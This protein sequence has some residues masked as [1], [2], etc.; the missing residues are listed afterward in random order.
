MNER[1]YDFL[2]RMREIHRP[3]RRNAQIQCQP[4]EIEI[5]ASWTLALEGDFGTGGHKALADLQDYLWTSMRL[6]LR[7]AEAGT[8]AAPALRLCQGAVDGPKGS[9][10]L[11][12]AERGIVLTAPGL[13]G[14]WSG[15]V[16]LEDTMNL[17][18]APLLPLGRQE[19]RPLIRVRRTH[20]GCGI[21]DFPDWQLAAIAHAGFNTIDVFL[22][23]FDQTTRGYCDIR[24]LI[25]RAAEYGLDTFIY[26]YMPSYK[27]PDDPDAEAFFDSIYGELFRRY[28]K[29]AGIGLC[30]ESLEFPSKDPAT[31]GKRWRE[32]MQDGI[33]D[34]R[35]SP[36]WWPCQDYPAY[37]RCIARAIR[38]VKPDA[39]IIFNTYNWGYSPQAQRRKF[40]ESLPKDIIVQTTF[41]IFKINRID[42]LSCPIMDYTILATE[43]GDYFT[44]ECAMAHEL[45]LE[46]C[47]TTNT[48]GATWDFGTAPYVPA[49]YRWIKRFRH[50][51]E[52]LEKWG[53]ARHYET[54]HY[55]W[56]P[57]VVIDLRKANDWSPREEDLE[58]LLRRVAA[59]DYGEA[60]AD[61]VMA[62]WRL[63]SEAMDHYVASN[64]DQYGPWRVG[65]A[66]PLMFQPN[67][68][69]TR[70]SKEID[71]PAAPHAHF[72]G[73]I[74]K[75][76]Y[77]PYE[78]ARQ[79]PGPLRFPK[80]LKRLERMLA[81]WRLG[82]VEVEA[83]LAGMP[84]SKRPDGERLLALGRFIEHSIVT[85]I[86]VKRWWLLN[87]R[88]QASDNPEAMLAIVD[89]LVALAE[90]EMR[91]ARET[92][93][94]VE[95]DSRL[96][97]E[98]SMEYVCDK[99]HLEWKIRQVQSA[100]REIA[101]YRQMLEL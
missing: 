27:H 80:E 97:W 49:P 66:Y 79:S 23:N 3:G 58:G 41:E 69:M 38:K 48:I 64:E 35:P 50:L 90:A 67:I 70:S 82:V 83:A 4:V 57:N 9:F 1:N 93:P 56:W 73:R 8:G 96:G 33:P 2:A 71:F 92:M 21:D 74:V 101:T 10:T 32:S 14:L 68:T 81:Q 100:L 45:G 99:W 6:S 12:I 72:G 98:P 78:N 17:R 34:T 25:D 87:T 86:H 31:T 22:K 39:E 24:G 51:N 77:Q 85:T 46:L 20:S 13:S 84:A 44:T 52:A 40:L 36:G 54:H 18:E 42:G 28:P 26:N 65:P 88:L 95:T 15:I 7:L 61:R 53:L 89:E 60:A 62:A 47:A 94:A 59:R 5:K 29:A 37:L 75:T 91:N 63:W 43:P 11:D 76:L 16:Y 19:R 55:G 30:G